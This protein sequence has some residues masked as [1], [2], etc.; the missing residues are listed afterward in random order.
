MMKNLLL[1]FKK[2]GLGL[3]LLVGMLVG[4]NTSYGQITTLSAWSNFYSGTGNYS[5]SLT[6]ASG[7]NSNRV[8]VVGIATSTQTASA[9]T[10]TLTY[11]GQSLTPV[12]GNLG[13]VVRQ[14]TQLYY[15]NE[16]GIDAAIGSTLSFSVSVGTTA[17]NSVFT[18]VYDNVDQNSPITD[19]KIY[20]SGTGTATTFQ[21]ATGLTINANNLALKVLSSV[22]VGNTTARTIS[23]FGTNWTAANQQT[24]NYNTSPNANDLGIRNVVGQRSIPSSN[25]T[26]VSATTMSGA[27]LISMTGLSL[28][29][30]G[31]SLSVTP[32]S[33]GFGEFCLNSTVGP[34]NFTISGAYLTAVNVTVSSLTG[35]TFSTTSG[36]SYTPSLSLTQAGGSYSQTIFVKFT[37]TT[38]TNYDGNISI[39]GGGATSVDV[40]VTGAG[41]NTAPTISSPTSTNI[42]ESS[43]NLGGNITLIGCSDVTER[44]I[45]WSTTN[46]FADGTGTKVS[47]TGTYSTGTFTVPVTGLNGNTVY[48]YKAFATNNGGTIYTSQGTFTTTCNV[49]GNPADF[50]N[51]EWNVYGYNGGNISD[52]NAITYRGFYTVTG[53]NFDTRASWNN[54]TSPS[55]ASG[56][57]GCTVNV[58]NMTFV[59]KRQ[60]FPCGM[61]QISVGHDD[62]A[63]L[64]I[65]GTQEWAEANWNSTPVNAGTFFLDETSTVELRVQD[66]N[67]AS[68]G[69]L[70]FVYTSAVAAT[71]IISYPICSGATNI[72]GTSSEADG[73]II[74]IFKGGVSLGTTTV[75]GGTWTITGLAALTGGNVITATA[76]ATNKC[77]SSIST[78]VIVGEVPSAPV[79]TGGLIC[80]GSTA[81]LSAS[82]GGAGDQY[83]WYD[84][85]A[86]GNLLQSGVSTTYVTPVL[87]STTNY[88]VSIS[89]TGGCEGPRTQVTATYPS[90]SSDNQNADGTDSWIGHVYD[91]VDF[92]TYFGSYIEN[93]TFDQSFG[94]SNNCFNITSNSV[95]RSIYTETFSVKYKMTSSRQGLYVVDLG[96]D[97]K[98]RL[99]IDGELVY[100][101]WIDQPWTSNPRVLINL[102]GSSALL[103]EFTENAGQNRVVF[104][105]L[106]RILANNLSTNTSQTICLGDLGS[107][108]IG[109]V[110]GT[111]PTGIALSGTGYQWA[112]STVSATGPWTD[113]SGA[114][115]ATYTPSAAS[116]PFNA[117]GTYYLMRKAVLISASNNTGVTNFLATNISNTATL[118]VNTSIPVSVSIGA[119]ATTVC[120]G[121]SVTYT[122]TPTNGGTTAAYQW[123]INGTN[124]GTNS[125]TYSYTPL[126]NDEISCVLTSSE[127]C[128]SGSPATS[129]SVTMTVN[130]ALPVSINIAASSNPVCAGTSVTYTATPTNGG[131]TPAYQ[132]KVNGSNVGTNSATYSYTPLNNDE[133]SC[134]LTSS[135]TCATGSPATSNS[136]TVMIIPVAGIPIFTSG[137]T[138]ICQNDPDETYAAT[139]ASSS[140]ISYSVLPVEAGTINTSSGVM[141]W[142]ASFYGTATIKATATG[143]CGTQNADRTV[144]VNPLPATG[145]IIA[146]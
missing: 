11:G 120:S 51:N 13:E 114:T 50:G 47:T 94:G 141:N 127:T 121:T 113:I 46:G 10:V 118:I 128:A 40:S 21:F 134:V 131:T 69:Q 112:Y 125:A 78:A 100:D 105:N 99:T 33:S 108:I 32:I 97:D 44:G 7:T 98:S 103:Y 93:E 56:Y 6:L 101:N 68:Y 140:S 123:K 129:N 135:E 110:Y 5:G 20:S 107:E 37:P 15:L 89:N 126:N 86:S 48:Y 119:T 116:T 66:G 85:A 2:I 29:S 87:G 124:V 53:L 106:T 75:S 26:D 9:R 72:S 39:G 109:D 145:P 27:T 4:V 139:A 67:G 19:S 142:S 102:T 30:A 61:Y 1:S 24:G 104:S 70:V 88:W 28:K 45:Y 133:I 25:T 57:Q 31:P 122:A 73:T 74:E 17:I 12:D 60:G 43:A 52:L 36:G 117:A 65:N 77:L 71:P 90:I 111:L 81:T 3:A 38:A 41:I 18:G 16:A 115:S 91:G 64:Y 143:D 8:L 23:N 35:Y 132:W 83:N 76:S 144:I 82:G 58:D 14:H 79:T 137:A 42:T 146:D 92:N 63:R 136:I 95:S 49:A 62:D 34:Q 84:A 54:M 138:E 22:R 59:H 130:T 96:S 80:I 55:S